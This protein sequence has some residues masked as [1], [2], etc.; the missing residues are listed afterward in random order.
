MLNTMTHWYFYLCIPIFEMIGRFIRTLYTFYYCLCHGMDQILRQNTLCLSTSVEY[1]RVWSNINIDYWTVN[2]MY[3]WMPWSTIV[4]CSDWWKNGHQAN[5]WHWVAVKISTKRL[6]FI[7][8]LEW[9]NSR[10]I[11][12]TATTGHQGGTRSNNSSERCIHFFIVYATEWTKFSDKTH[13]VFQ[14]QLNI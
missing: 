4:S 8:F 6:V 14:H 12:T 5:N 3:L 9:S 2:H 13:Y 7:T 11:T 1:I 10:L